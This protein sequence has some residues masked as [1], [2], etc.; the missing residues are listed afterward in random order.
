M[1]RL[2][3]R[4]PSGTPEHYGA[5]SSMAERLVFALTRL[6]RASDIHAMNRIK[7]ITKEVGNTRRHYLTAVDVETLLSR[8]PESLWSRLRE[9]Y[10]NDRSR[11]NRVLGYVTGGRRT[12]TICALPGGISLGCAMVCR[13]LSAAEFG[14]PARGRW[15]EAAVRRYLLY[16]TFLHEIGHLQ[17]ARPDVKR[18]RRRFASETLAQ[19]FANRWRRRLWQETFDHPDPVHNAPDKVQP[20]TQ[21]HELTNFTTALR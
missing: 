5:C 9:V 4:V 21:Q 15:P 10:F 13:R 20:R 8:L 6:V 1:E 11:G 3:V 7:F 18:T 2:W 14:A 16:N 17:V 19:S 12:I